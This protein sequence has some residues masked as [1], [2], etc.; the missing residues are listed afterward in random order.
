MTTTGYHTGVLISAAA[1][2]A[3]LAL[4]IAVPAVVLSAMAIL[5]WLMSLEIGSTTMT[6][7]AA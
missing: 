2:F 4:D 6:K 7:R 1:F 5:R 3:M